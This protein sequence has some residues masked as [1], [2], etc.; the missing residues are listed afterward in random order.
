MKNEK[1]IMK[2]ELWKLMLVAIVYFG[3]ELW[4]LMLVAIVYFGFFISVQKWRI[5][6]H[7]RVIPA[8]SLSKHK[9]R[10]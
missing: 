2:N 8:G 6:E 9:G 7:R 10:L 3:Y 4:K 1:W 5:Y